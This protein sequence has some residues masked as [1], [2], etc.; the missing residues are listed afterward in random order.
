MKDVKNILNIL[1]QYS[2]SDSSLEDLIHA[3]RD[4]INLIDS[5]EYLQT[6]INELS[7]VKIQDQKYFENIAASVVKDVHHATSELKKKIDCYPRLKKVINASFFFEIKSKVKLTEYPIEE[8]PLLLIDPFLKLLN[9]ILDCGGT[10]HLIT[11]YATIASNNDRKFVREITFSDNI[12]TF[13]REAEHFRGRRDM[14]LWNLW[15]RISFF[16]EWTKNGITNSVSKEK[17][18]IF[19]DKNQIKY[20][21]KII[22]QYLLYNTLK[23]KTNEEC[24]QAPLS[25]I[26]RNLLP[27]PE[28]FIILA[29]ELFIEPFECQIWILS[30]H[31]NGEYTPHFVAWCKDGSNPHQF[32]MHLRC[33]NKGTVLND[34]DLPRKRNDLGI[35]GI[36]KD[37]FFL[38]SKIFNGSYVRISELPFK[39]SNEQLLAALPTAK[40]RTPRFPVEAYREHG[41]NP[42]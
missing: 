40:Q 21:F 20:A 6:S 23:V 37:I 2:D 15:E 36:L 38:N 13:C 9:A 27:K 14:A 33:L 30:H 5:H 42:S 29:L 16:H 7:K 39:I 41:K 11:R 12:R 22:C 34:T 18:E 24:V 8:R 31:N 17:L 1:L 19:I 32:A 10:E 25:A 35:K 4:L 26:N 3:V 28:T